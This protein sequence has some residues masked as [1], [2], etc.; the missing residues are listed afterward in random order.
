MLLNVTKF[1]HFGTTV[2]NENCIHDEIKCRLNSGNACYSGVQNLLSSHLPKNI[3]I[4]IYATA[5]LRVV[6]YGREIWPLTLSEQLRLRTAS[7]FMLLMSMV[8]GDVSELQSSPRRYI[9][10][11]TVEWYWQG[12]QKNSEIS[13]QNTNLSPTNP[14]WTHPSTNLGLHV[15]RPATNCLS[16]GTANRVLSRIFVLI[17]Q[18]GWSDIRV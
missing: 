1:K 9:W 5:I 7:L 2:R 14:T 18:E 13:Y 4:K 16:H 15:E 11:L 3:K 17:I 10:R 8:W 12:R 6:Y